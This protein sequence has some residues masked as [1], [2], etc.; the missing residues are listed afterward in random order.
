MMPPVVD[1]RDWALRVRPGAEGSGGGLQAVIEGDLASMSGL[2]WTLVAASSVAKLCGAVNACG[3]AG[4]PDSP[5]SWSEPT[6][7]GEFAST[8]MTELQVAA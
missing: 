5:W 6:G 4:V 3:A 7:L 8:R 2:S 1:Q